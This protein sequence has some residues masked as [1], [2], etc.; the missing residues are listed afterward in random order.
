MRLFNSGGRSGRPNRSSCTRWSAGGTSQSQQLFSSL[1]KCGP[2]ALLEF[3]VRPT[4]EL[5]KKPPMMLIE[6]IMFHVIDAVR[7]RSQ[8]S[9][10]WRDLP[11]AAKGS[12]ID[13][14]L[15]P[16]AAQGVPTSWV[17]SRCPS[18]ISKPL[19]NC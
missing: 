4:L 13:V 19:Q 14:D 15:A 2:S 16:E 3:T 6:R 18:S 5:P 9:A 11:V 1:R 10:V 12:E 17:K 7:T 8:S